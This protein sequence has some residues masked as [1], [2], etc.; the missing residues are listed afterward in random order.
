MT[1][2]G[3]WKIVTGT[4]T[5]MM[6]VGHTLSSYAKSRPCSY[7]LTSEKLTD[8]KDKKACFPKSQANPLD[9]TPKYSNVNHVD[10]SIVILGV[11]ARHVADPLGLREVELTMP[12]WLKVRLDGPHEFFAPSD[13]R[14]RIASAPSPDIPVSNLDGLVSIQIKP[15]GLLLLFLRRWGWRR[16][17]WGVR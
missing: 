2:I 16:R 9:D 3:M 10:V 6:I 13:A 5:R 8:E 15:H 4:R 17:R 11:P 7:L 12:M 1:E 14:V